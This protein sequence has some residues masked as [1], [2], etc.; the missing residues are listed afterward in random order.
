[1]SQLDVCVKCLTAHFVGRHTLKLRSTLL[2]YII[3]SEIRV[4]T[5]AYQELCHLPKAASNSPYECQV[6]L[7]R[8]AH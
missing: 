6:A 2:T 8:Q 1:M 7:Q 3:H 5:M 4:D